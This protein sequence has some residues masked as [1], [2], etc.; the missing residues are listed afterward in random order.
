VKLPT[1]SFIFL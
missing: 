1:Y